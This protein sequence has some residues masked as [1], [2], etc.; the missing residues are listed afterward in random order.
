MTDYK[1]VFIDMAPFIYFIEKAESIIIFI[2]KAPTD[3][4][5]I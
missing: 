4:L 2:T 3:E 1:K 5:I